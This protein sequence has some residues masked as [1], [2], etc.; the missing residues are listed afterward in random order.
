LSSLQSLAA[1][2]REEARLAAWEPRATA[3]A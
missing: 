3:D 1:L 2:T